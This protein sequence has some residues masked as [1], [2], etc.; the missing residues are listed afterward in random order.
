M[1]EELARCIN[2]QPGGQGDFWS[3]FPFSSP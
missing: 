2:P 1:R 3:R